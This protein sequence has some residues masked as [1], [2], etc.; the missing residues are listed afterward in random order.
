M[1]ERAAFWIIVGMLLPVVVTFIVYY[2][3]IV[4]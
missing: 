1:R 3:T 4:K 2:A